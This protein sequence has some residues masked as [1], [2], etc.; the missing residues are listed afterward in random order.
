MNSTPAPTPLSLPASDWEAW[1][2]ERCDGQLDQAR[3]H[4]ETLKRGGHDSAAVL[5]LW[6]DLNLALHNAFAS[7]G[8]FSNVHPE[9]AVRTRA[10]RA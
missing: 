1:L 4:V 7:A 3:A 6:N 10:E 5:G 8:L 9:E 2:A